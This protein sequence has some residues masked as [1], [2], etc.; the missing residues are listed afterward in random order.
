MEAAAREAGITYDPRQQRRA[1]RRGAATG[2]DA[3]PA[4]G[5]RA[6]GRPGGQASETIA[7]VE[8]ETSRWWC[9]PPPGGSDADVVRADS[10]G[11]ALELGRLLAGLGH[12]QMAVLSGPAARPHGRRPRRG[13]PPGRWSTRPGSRSRRLVRCVPIDSGR[14]MT[15]PAMAWFRARPHCSPRTTSSRS[16]SCTRS[17]ELG[18]VGPGRRRGGRLRRPAGGD[19]HLPVPDRRGTA[20]GEMGQR[21]SRCSSTASRTRTRPG[22]GGDPPHEARHPPLERRTRGR[23]RGNLIPP[24]K[25]STTPR[26]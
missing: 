20:R 15:L 7:L 13:L 11:G 5:R 1:C 18:L 16:A 6:P 19:G 9:R 4:P 21:A 14:E 24:G 8:N 25:D 26:R 22:A 23:R 3:P 17:T 10:E 2:P 12:R